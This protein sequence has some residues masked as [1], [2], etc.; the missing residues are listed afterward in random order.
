M[1]KTVVSVALMKT[2]SKL[3]PWCLVKHKKSMKNFF[4]S[5]SQTKLCLSL[6]KNL[7]C[8]LF[9]NGEGAS[10]LFSIDCGMEKK[11]YAAHVLHQ[12]NKRAQLYR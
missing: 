1:V 4:N 11:N 10:Q 9:S 8:K 7:T 3:L 5:L 2:A 12:F 6:V